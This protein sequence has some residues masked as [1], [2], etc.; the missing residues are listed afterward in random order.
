MQHKNWK[1]I[2]SEAISKPEKLFNKLNIS[3]VSPISVKANKDFALRV[4]PG[5]LSRINKNDPD[6]PLLRQVLPIVE[7]EFKQNGYTEDPLNEVSRQISPGLL[8]KYQGRVL[9]VLTGACAIHC[10]YC[11]R[12]HFPYADSNPSSVNLKKAIKY[13]QKETSVTE[14]ILSG[15]DPLSVSDQRL[16]ELILQLGNIPHIKR[17]RIHTRYPVVV[18]ERIN[19]ECLAWM[20]QTR[21]QLAIVLHINHANELDGSVQQA[22]NKLKAHHIPLFNQSVLLKNVNDSVPVLTELSETLFS[23]G[24]IPYYLH[25]LDP[26]AGASHFEVK[27]SDAKSLM[28]ELQKKLPGYL[29]P[30]LVREDYDTPHK[31]IISYC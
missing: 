8:H 4:P 15:G 26:V 2:T 24:I 28:T 17:L 11:F 29:L 10:R 18:P 6:D 12:R 14:V 3:D 31:T 1:K 13:L 22:L 30:K 16:S 25:L 7:E 20:T 9:L 27:E 23:Y 21:L 19:D 5:Y